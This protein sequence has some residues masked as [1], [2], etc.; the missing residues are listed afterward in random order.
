MAEI[1]EIVLRRDARTVS[2]LRPYLAPRFVEDAARFMLDRPGP[3]LIASGFYIVEADNVETDGLPG[4][5]SRWGVPCRRWG[6]RCSTS[7][8]A[9]RHRTWAQK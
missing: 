1:E 5:P 9:T 4:A 8:T 7:P 3:V 6:G 2:L